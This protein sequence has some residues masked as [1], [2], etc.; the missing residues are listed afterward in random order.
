VNSAAD[1]LINEIINSRYTAGALDEQH[2]GNN[3]LLIWQNRLE[4]RQRMTYEEKAKMI[5][6]TL[7]NETYS[8]VFW[9]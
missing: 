5:L 9:S 1:S 7:D 2:A 8:S 3:V 4:W 6:K